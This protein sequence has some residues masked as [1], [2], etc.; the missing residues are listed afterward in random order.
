M[1]KIQLY[2]NITTN[3]IQHDNYPNQHDNLTTRHHDACMYLWCMYVCVNVR[4]RYLFNRV[5]QSTLMCNL[6][7]VNKRQA[8]I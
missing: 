3:A 6:V 7:K 2:L 1:N 5:I 8:T 4:M